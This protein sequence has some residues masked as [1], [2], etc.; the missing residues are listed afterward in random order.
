MSEHN[1]KIIFQLGIYTV[2]GII[3]HVQGQTITVSLAGTGATSSQGR[4]QITRNGTTGTVCNDKFD[5]LAAAVVCRMLGFTNGGTAVV[6]VPTRFGAGTGQIWLDDV[7]CQGNEN[8]IELCLF[9]PWGESNCGHNEDVAVV[10]NTS[11]VQPSSVSPI[12]TRAPATVQ[13]SNCTVPSSNIRLVGPSNLKGIGF[14]EVYHNGVWGSVCDDSWGTLD[15]RVVCRMLCFN[16]NIAQAGAPADINYVKDQVSKN[17]LLDEVQCFGNETDIEQ[18][19]KNPWGVHDCLA[20]KTEYASVTCVPLQNTQPVAPVP[21][22][23][24]SGGKFYARFSRIRDPNLEAKHLSIFYPYSGPC[25]N[26]TV[27]TATTVTIIISYSGCGTKT[28]VNSTHIFYT[29]SIRYDYTVIENLIVRVNTYRIE[30]VCEFPRDLEADKGFTPL[31][32]TVTQ[33]APGAFK[34]LISFFNDS[35][36]T[37]LNEPIQ[38][39]LGSWLNVALTLEAIDPNLKLIVPNCKATPTNDPKDPTIFKLFEDKCANDPT[40]GFFPLNSTSFGFRYQTF[41]FVQYSNVVLQCDAFVCLVSEKYAECDRTCQRANS[42]TSGRRKRDVSSEF[43]RPIY[44]VTSVP[45]TFHETGGDVIIDRGDGWQVNLVTTRQPTTVA[46]TTTSIGIKTETPSTS[47]FQNP[48]STTNVVLVTSTATPIPTTATPT[49]TAS[50]KAPTTTSQT[51]SPTTQSTTIT[52]SQVS[53]TTTSPTFQQ[54]ETPRP[55]TVSPTSSV[56][57][58][59]LST[60]SNTKQLIIDPDGPYEGGLGGQLKILS[61]ASFAFYSKFL[62][63][64]ISMSMTIYLLIR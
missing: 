61:G 53:S 40:L 39:T 1:F 12:T 41:K 34:I 45:M 43:S 55:T 8:S 50:T 5:D 30:V 54:T 24:C 32:E 47:L 9:R 14:V 11:P 21:D 62:T 29:N 7:T 37:V 42:T 2:L 4:V 36:H 56:A 26:E 15:A 46:M 18:C 49:T 23:E 31:T 58:D 27:T 6:D 22:L 59:Q 20:N 60:G 48:T 51:M 63:F 3:L 25:Q 57:H 64:F 17:F 10:C 52:K 38:L 13:P 28:T 16:Y 35:F 33:A 19:P 44:R